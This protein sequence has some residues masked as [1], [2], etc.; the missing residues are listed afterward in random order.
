MAIARFIIGLTAMIAAAPLIAQ[1]ADSPKNV[2]ADAREMPQTAALNTQVS[3]NN[4]AIDAQNAANQAQYDS[5]REAYA[6]AMRE[7]HRDVLATDDTFVR[8]Q[9]AYADAM[10]DYR[11]QV[12]ACKRGHQRAC[13]LPAP[14]PRNYM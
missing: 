6:A 11:V 14:D 12:A 3:G 9:V 2:A 4:A 10:R 7:H 5:D 8:Q 1:S 13:D